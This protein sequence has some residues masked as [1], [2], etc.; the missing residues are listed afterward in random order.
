[1]D[2]RYARYALAWQTRYLLQ[3]G[4]D[5]KT[6]GGNF[7]DISLKATVMGAADTLIIFKQRISTVLLKGSQVMCITDMKIVVISR[8]SSYTY[9]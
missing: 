7:V 9:L 4:M 8:G 5:S 3:D 6:A 2:K 1:M